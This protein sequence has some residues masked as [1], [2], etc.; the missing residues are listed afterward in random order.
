MPQRFRVLGIG[1]YS[2]DIRSRP[3]LFL[4]Y[5]ALSAPLVMICPLATKPK[6]GSR[7]FEIRSPCHL[8]MDHFILPSDSCH[9]NH[10]QYT[11]TNKKGRKALV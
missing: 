9:K 5:Y 11:E 8:G 7:P 10:C 2:S 4:N 1:G 3:R 6:L